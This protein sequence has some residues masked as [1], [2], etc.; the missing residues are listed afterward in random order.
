MHWRL[1]LDDD[2]YPA[3]EPSNWAAWEWVIARTVDDAIWYVENYGLP[4]HIAFDHDLGAKKMTGMDFA[5]WFS[6]YIL[7]KELP[8]PA[9]FGF[10]VHS[11]NPVGARNITHRMRYLLDEVS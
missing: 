11:M 7:G 4:Y 5:V 2:R 9:D 1:F 3:G 10:S 8:L 6:E